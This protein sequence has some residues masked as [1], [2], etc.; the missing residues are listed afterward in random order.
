MESVDKF[1]E[2]VFINLGFKKT[3]LANRVAFKIPIYEAIYLC[4]LSREEDPES[5]GSARIFLNRDQILKF[6]ESCP[7]SHVLDISPE[8]KYSLT[9]KGPSIREIQL[10]PLLSPSLKFLQEKCGKFFDK[11]FKYLMFDLEFEDIKEIAKEEGLNTTDIISVRLPYPLTMGEVPLLEFVF[12]CFLRK[13]GFIVDK[14][15]GDDWIGGDLYA[16][17]IPEIQNIL[18]DS[19]ITEGGF[20]LCELELVSVM[21]SNKKFNSKKKINKRKFIA[22]EVEGIGESKKTT[23]S[24]R[25]SDGRN[26][27]TEK[28][29]PEGYFDEGYVA[30]PFVEEKAKI[31]GGKPEE[32]GFIPEEDVGIITI[33]HNGT[34]IFKK[35]PKKYGNKEKIHELHKNIERIIKL[36]LLKNLPLKRTFSLLPN[37]RSFYDIFYLVDKLDINKIVDIIKQ[38]YDF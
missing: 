28:Y 36:T 17:K 19:G 34:F 21:R 11:D 26:Q 13:K 12:S 2:K 20:Y 9:T 31:I 29:L 22:V 7:Y 18:A 38:Q 10:N 37:T 27:L 32:L 5:E 15:A 1:W 24:S 33:D 14:F 4:Q 35:C 8:I 30:V 25:L 23:P 3:N 16:F 6:P